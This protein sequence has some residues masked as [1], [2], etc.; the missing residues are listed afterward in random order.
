[1]LSCGCGEREPAAVVH[2]VDTVTVVFT[3]TIGTE[4]G[5]GPYVFGTLMEVRHGNRGE[6]AV[7]DLHRACLSLYSTDGEYLGDIGAPGPGPGEFQVPVGFGTMSDGGFAVTDAVAGRVSFFDPDGSFRGSLEGFFP[8]PPMSVEGGPDG[9]LVG[10]TMSL[11]LTDREMS[12]SMDICRWR[13]DPEPELTYCSVPFDLEGLGRGRTSVRRGPELD[14]A[15]GPDGSVFVAELSDSLF[16]LRGFSPD[17]SEFLTVREE[18]ERTPLTPEELEAGSLSFSIS[19]ENGEASA[20]MGRTDDVHPWRSVIRSVGADRQGRIWVEMGNTDAPLFR[21]Y[22]HS[23]ELLFLAVT[24]V[25]FTQVGRPSFTVDRGGVLAF[26][27][28]PEDYP[29]VYVGSVPE[30]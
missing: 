27:R 29:K 22:D 5:D 26:D 6:I 2:G 18:M 15:A 19:I 9:S 21:V 13:D 23:G 11:V 20:E 14:F 10:M 17:G 30:F 25:P 28:D 7:L 16:L 24:D 8:T 12:A 4:F 1:M 3:D